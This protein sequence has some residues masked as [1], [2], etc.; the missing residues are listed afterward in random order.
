MENIDK[1]ISD[2]ID[3]FKDVLLEKYGNIIGIYCSDH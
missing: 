3:I 2:F 1:E